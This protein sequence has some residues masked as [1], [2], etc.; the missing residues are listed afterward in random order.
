MHPKC[1]SPHLLTPFLESKDLDSSVVGLWGPHSNTTEDLG[2]VKLLLQQGKMG[3]LR[4]VAS[5]I[6]PFSVSVP[7]SEDGC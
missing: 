4:K 3:D 6:Y 1:L 5:A 2:V 7:F